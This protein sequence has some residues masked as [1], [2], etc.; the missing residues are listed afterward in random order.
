MNEIEL[1]DGPPVERTT[2]AIVPTTPAQLLTIAVQRGADLAQ[3]ER[4]MDLQERFEKRE[5]EKAYNAAFTAFKAESIEVI[6]RKR[7]HFTSAKGT[8]DYKHAEL[9]D[10]IEAATPALAM[11]GLSASW[12]VTKEASDWIE[13]TCTLRHTLGHSETVSMGGPPD[14][15]GNKNKL[16]ARASTVTYLE[17]YTFKAICGLAEKGQDNDGSPPP[18][19]SAEDQALIEAGQAAAM[20]GMAALTKWW[21]SLDNK[22]RG[23]MNKPFAEMRR[24]A[25]LADREAA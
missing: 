18:D 6:K 15:S 7:V 25:Q 9:S 5:A 8:T 3:L 21:G 22:Q 23:R 2:T 4:L 12:K 10:V 16:Q 1:I 14:D 17:R 24:A 11:H 20:E 19:T 13:V